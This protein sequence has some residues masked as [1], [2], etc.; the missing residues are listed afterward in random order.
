MTAY[1]KVLDEFETLSRIS[2]WASGQ[3]IARF[4]DGEFNLCWGHGI[5]C[6][7]YDAGLADRLRDILKHP[8]EQCLV[9]IP[10]LR[11]KTPKAQFW[12]K[13]ERAAELL[14]PGIYASS[15]ITRP[16]S[17]PWVDTDRFW[18]EWDG[19]W[20]FERITLV[21]G[22]GR[23]LLPSDLLG[24]Q[25]REIVAPPKDAWADYDRLMREIGTPECV[26]LCLGPTATV[27]AYDLC[28]K[29]VHAI[30][31]GHLGMFWRKHK[32]GL[33]MTKTAEDDRAA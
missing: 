25:V 6:Q 2:G 32:A 11:S 12:R 8:D 14:A 9:G 17:A 7:R 31:A 18:A 15:F 29:G 4:G 5:P 30:D 33:P 16:D 23:S 19:L 13:Y 20:S 22:S 26:L 24:A 28:A 27:L 21:R 10:N 3:S 1:P